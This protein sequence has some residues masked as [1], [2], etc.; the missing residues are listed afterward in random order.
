MSPYEQPNRGDQLVELGVQ[1]LE[2]LLKQVH[3][4][5][6]QGDPRLQEPVERDCA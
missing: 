4:G 5:F 3:L 2:L 6:L 1:M